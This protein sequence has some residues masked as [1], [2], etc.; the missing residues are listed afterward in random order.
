MVN[1]NNELD[2]DIKKIYY[3]VFGCYPG[4]G[5][6]PAMVTAEI[7][8]HYERI[9][10]NIPQSV[11]WK[12]SDAVYLGCNK[13]GADLI[14]LDTP[15]EILGLTDYDLEKRLKWSSG[16]ADSFRADDFAVIKSKKP[17][18]S[19][20]EKSFNN[21]EGELVY[22]LTTRVPF[23]YK[24]NR[25]GV[26]GIST[27]ITQFKLATLNKL[28]DI[29]DKANEEKRLFMFIVSTRVRTLLSGIQMAKQILTGPSNQH[30][31]DVLVLLDNVIEKI[32]RL[33]THTMDYLNLATYPPAALFN[34]K[35]VIEMVVYEQSSLMRKNNIILSVNYDRSIPS[36]LI[37]ESR[38]IQRIIETL[39][40]NALN[41]T[42]EGLVEI[43]IRI[44]EMTTEK[45]FVDIVVKDNGKGISKELQSGLFDIFEKTS[46]DNPY[47][48]CGFILSLT[49]RWV[50]NL[51]GTISVQSELGH[52]SEFVVT[53]PLLLCEKQPCTAPPLTI[54]NKITPVIVARKPWLIDAIEQFI[55][56][57]NPL[58]VLNDSDPFSIDYQQK[59][60]AIIDGYL[61]DAFVSQFIEAFQR[62][63]NIPF[64]IA[65]ID[66]FKDNISYVNLLNPN[67]VAIKVALPL[68]PGQF[69]RE[70]IQ[71]YQKWSS[72]QWARVRNAISQHAIRVLYA[73]DTPIAAKALEIGF[74]AAHC[75]SVHAPTGEVAIAKVIDDKTQQFDIMFLD[76]GLPGKSG[77]EVASFIRAHPIYKDIPIIAQTAFV[78]DDDIVRCAEIGITDVINKPVSLQD[79]QRMLDRYVRHPEDESD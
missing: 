9:I 12:D 52:G 13:A 32:L 68:T 3:D 25:I 55:P 21:A 36:Q 49:K 43:T 2:N 58:C 45:L 41:Y 47:Q 64:F 63:R 53:L 72:G 57:D 14:G 11:Y 77:F 33:F 78:S 4:L 24:K 56:L 74:N 6:T 37:G 22:Q 26:I 50:E 1:K 46:V 16:V 34:L 19:V 27:D 35:E 44:K 30:C 60:I 7:K 23:E 40:V 18:K 17:V 28:N 76:L 61:D 54:K 70:F 29:L 69:D 42:P 20:E 31:E 10:N 71:N 65:V 67:T 48:S 5:L 62:G 59:S 8:S 66:N 15:S 51:G 39:I 38:K 73:E 79:I 75:L